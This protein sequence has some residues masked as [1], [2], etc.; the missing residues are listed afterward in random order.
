MV[1]IHTDE[2]GREVLAYRL[3]TVYARQ[4]GA[5]P[6]L[7][8]AAPAVCHA[9]GRQLAPMGGGG[10]FLAPEIVLA[11]RNEGCGK[12]VVTGAW[13]D[14]VLGALRD[15]RASLPDGDPLASRI[16]GL[17]REA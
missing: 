2:T 4:A 15:A 12:A 1:G 8:T 14:G 6:A 7:V 5:P 16:D 13:L 10:L 17:L 3:D 11:L 9:T